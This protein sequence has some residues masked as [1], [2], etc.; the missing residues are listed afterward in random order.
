MALWSILPGRIGL[1]T[2][3][4]WIEPG[5]R[6]MRPTLA[7]GSGTWRNAASR[8]AVV[9]ENLRQ[10]RRLTRKLTCRGGTPPGG[11]GGSRED[12][13]PVRRFAAGKE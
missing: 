12:L 1:T 6:R 10:V 4:T 8:W 5:G 7:F 9:R 13:T 3:A 11:R 2:K